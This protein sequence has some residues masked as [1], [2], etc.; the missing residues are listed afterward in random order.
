MSAGIRARWCVR[1]SS[2]FLV[3]DWT[4]RYDERSH[5]PF[6]RKSHANREVLA[7][8][9]C[10]DHAHMD[11]GIADVYVCACSPRHLYMSFI[12]F[13]GSFG[14]SIHPSRVSLDFQPVHSFIR[15]RADP[16]FLIDAL[17]HAK[18]NKSNATGQRQHSSRSTRERWEVQRKRVDR[19]EQA[20]R[21]VQDAVWTPH[22]P[23]EF[24]SLPACPP[25]SFISVRPDS[26]YPW[27]GSASALLYF[28]PSNS[29]LTCRING[30][31]ALIYF[32]RSFVANRG[33]HAFTRIRLDDHFFFDPQLLYTH[34]GL[35]K[36]FVILQR[37][38]DK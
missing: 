7:R 26:S 34:T 35:Y 20:A 38:P 36:V 32:R 18:T 27:H 5:F 37:P 10:T 19:F 4:S 12:P 22:R 13:G 6:L 21:S 33:K 16:R 30:E 15:E 29:R 25:T 17:R 11:A 1:F 14:S 2:L 3:N 8:T 28:L 9:Q 23:R 31:F 24:Q